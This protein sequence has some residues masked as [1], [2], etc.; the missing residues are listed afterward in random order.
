MILA[1]TI[2]IGDISAGI[3][4]FVFVVGVASAA[5][6]YF[7]RRRLATGSTET[8][9]A[10]VLWD[11]AQKMRAELQDQLDAVTEQRDKLVEFQSAQVLPALGSIAA[12]LNQITAALTRLEGKSDAI[13]KED[14]RGSG[15]QG[16]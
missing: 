16:R 3:A 4:I 8:S 10:D 9:D 13:S 12:S 7:L 2:T 1:S 11:Q 6:T 14:E 5:I 15:Q